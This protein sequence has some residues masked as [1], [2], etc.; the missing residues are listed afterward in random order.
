MEHL[1]ATEVA[2]ISLLIFIGVLI[3]LKVPAQIMGAL[4]ARSQEIAKELRDARKL[5][6]DAEALLVDYE[7][8]RTAAETEAKAIVEQAKEQAV[9][10]AEQTRTSMLDAIARRE[11]QAEERIAQAESRAAGEVRAAAID[12]AMAAAERMIG[13]RMS[14]QTQATLVHA[15][16]SELERKF[17]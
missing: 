5:R 13:E 12:A 16:V 9:L 7:A 10:V 14:D 4:D 11:R 3:W 8:K 6:E 2:F 15:G 1:T 17:G